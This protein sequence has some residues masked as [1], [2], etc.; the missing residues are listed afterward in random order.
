MRAIEKISLLA[1][2]VAAGDDA[3]LRTEYI[4]RVD[5]SSVFYTPWNFAFFYMNILLN[6]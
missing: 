4:F 2:F 1:Y 3:F 6:R 5:L